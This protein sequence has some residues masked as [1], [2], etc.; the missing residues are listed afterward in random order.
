MNE[1]QEKIDK[2]LLALAS[3]SDEWLK[4]GEPEYLAEC[5]REA[6]KNARKLLAEAGI[7]EAEVIVHVITEYKERL[8]RIEKEAWS[9]I[10]IANTYGTD[11]VGFIHTL[12][13]LEAALEYD[14]N[15]EAK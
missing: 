14:P 8:R 1:K 2:F 9:V 4:T 13:R 3:Y 11:R 6:V 15:K 12:Y 7:E 10:E 5:F